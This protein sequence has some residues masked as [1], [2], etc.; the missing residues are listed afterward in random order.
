MF[1][2]REELQI[3]MPIAHKL[4]DSDEQ[5]NAVNAAVS[6]F[7]SDR[8]GIPVPDSPETAPV[9]CKLPSCQIY[10]WLITANVQGMSPEEL[11]AREQ[12]YQNALEALD[13]HRTIQPTGNIIS[14]FNT[15]S[16]YAW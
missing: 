16:K 10:N 5:F 4:T 14:V 13:R 1:I 7:I 6:G 3:I 2:S 12:S 9:W 15:G 11:T 8:V